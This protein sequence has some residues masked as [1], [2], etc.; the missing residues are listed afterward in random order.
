MANILVIDDDKD[1]LRLM[2]FTLKR[3]GHAVTTRKSGAEGLAYAESEAP[4][5]VIVDVMMPGMNGYEFCTKMRDNPTLGDTPIIVFSAHYQSTGK[6][7]ALEAGADD[8]IPKTILPDKLLRRV[9][10]LLAA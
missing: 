7:N 3:A 9:S 1:I 8:Y 2:E 4:D 5:L 10:D 6:R